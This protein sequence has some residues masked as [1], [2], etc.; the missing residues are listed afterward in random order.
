MSGGCTPWKD[1]IHLIPLKDVV[2][3]FWLTLILQHY[4]EVGDSALGF[5]KICVS[6]LSKSFT[7]L[8]Q[9]ASL[10]FFSH[11]ILFYIT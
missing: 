10:S 4:L 3:L 1:D 11:D 8:Y 7:I 6:V 2:G 5:L 9:I